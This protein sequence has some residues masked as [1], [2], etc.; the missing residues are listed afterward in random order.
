M[1]TTWL[2]TIISFSFGYLLCYFT[3]KPEKLQQVKKTIGNTINR[4][5]VGTVKSLSADQLRLR[6]N[7][8]ALDEDRLMEETFDKLLDV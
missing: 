5:R 3:T 7:K 2:I 8:D 6:K 4:P 1:I